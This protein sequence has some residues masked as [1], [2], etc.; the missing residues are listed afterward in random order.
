MSNAGFHEKP[1]DAGSLTKLKIFELY[2]Q[3]WIPVFVSQP[4]P[5]FREIHLF[6]LFSGPGTD[7]INQP[8]S[9]LRMLRQL[10][11]YEKRGMAGWSKVE[12]VVHL[13]DADGIKTDRLRKLVRHPDWM[14][15]G[16]RVEIETLSFAEAL[17]KHA[18][19]LSNPNVAKLL[20][21][22]QFGVDAISEEV[23]RFL[24][25]APRTDFIFFLSSFALH[26]FRD[27]PAIKIKIGQV[28]DSYDVHRVAYEWYSA[29][30][31]KSAYL[32]RF[33]IKKGSNIYG[34]IFGSQHPLGAHKFLEV[35]WKNDEIR[36]EANFDIDRENI[37]AD[38]PLLPM[39]FLRPKKVQAFEADLETALRAGK[40]HD[41]AALVHYCIAAGM[42]GQHAKPVLQKLKMDGAIEC[43]FLVPNVRNLSTPRSIR[44]ATRS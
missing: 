17:R 29:L 7:A 1:Y 35:A 26:R 6:D 39:D 36:G 9:P 3:E 2:V 18:G 33:S 15:P 31:P 43:E 23:F 19:I 12:I 21:L 40:I 10:R 24:I 28:E 34:L 37:A 30:T 8:G 32:G 22:D 25:T 41:E 44:N 27:H 5:R 13:S 20:I 42:T 16:V 4:E 14:A 38:E 11:S